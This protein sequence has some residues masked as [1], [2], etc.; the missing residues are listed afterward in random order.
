M[1]RTAEIVLD[2]QTYT[3]RAFNIGELEIIQ[4]ANND[5]WIVLRTALRRA[6][7]KVANVD[8]LEPT[9]DELTAAFRTI[10]ELAGFKAPD[11][12]TQAAAAAS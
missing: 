4:K 10:M 8:E 5:V 3:I 1:A 2:G 6:E 12:P 7:P 11:D 9:S